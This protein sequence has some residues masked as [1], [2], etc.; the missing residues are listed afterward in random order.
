MR[1]IVDILLNKEKRTYQIDAAD[2]TQVK[3]RLLLRLP[4]QQR[5][6][7]KIENIKIDP[8]S[9]LESEPYGIFSED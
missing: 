6:I 1:Y 7:C 3:E 5:D 8:K 9:L 2:E 4:P